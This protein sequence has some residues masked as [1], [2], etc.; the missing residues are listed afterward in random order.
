[1]I[2]PV[3]VPKLKIVY[4]YKIKILFYRP[5]LKTAVGTLTIGIAIEQKK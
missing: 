3:F 5:L 1:M 2:K 4:K